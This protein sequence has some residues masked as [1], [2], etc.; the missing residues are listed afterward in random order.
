MKHFAMMMAA[1]ILL[2]ISRLGD[3]FKPMGMKKPAGAANKPTT[4]VDDNWHWI[5]D[6]AIE[7]NSCF[8]AA[9]DAVAAVRLIIHRHH[10]DGADCAAHLGQQVSH[11]TY[12]SANP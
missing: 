1:I 3:A 2:A 8:A 4:Y 12:C 7:Q 6:K 9:Q 10:A 11:R 5:H